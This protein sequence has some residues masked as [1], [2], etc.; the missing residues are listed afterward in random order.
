VRTIIVRIIGSHGGAR[1]ASGMIARLIHV[2][3]KVKLIYWSKFPEWRKSFIRA[4]TG[5]I[6]AFPDREAVVNVT[7]VLS[8]SLVLVSNR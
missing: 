8:H 7:L 2:H 1:F 6:T 4:H 5:Q 3:I